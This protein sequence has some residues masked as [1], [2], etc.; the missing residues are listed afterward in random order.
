MADEE[1]GKELHGRGF[2]FVPAPGMRARLQR[3]GFAD[4]EGFA[5]S[6]NDL[7]LDIYMAD[8]GRYRRRRHAAFAVGAAAIERKPHQPHYQSRD[9]NPLNGGIERWFEPIADA[10]GR[11]P[12]MQAV[13]RFAQALFDPLTPPELRP[14]AW[15]AEV[16]QFRVEAHTGQPGLPTPEGM[17]RDGVDWVL[18]LLVARENVASGATTILDAA[19]HPVG[20]FLLAAPL[21]TALVDDSR[22]FHG[23]TPIA[24]LETTRSGHRDVL[25]VTLRR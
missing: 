9:Y 23:V 13:L 25:V 12:A 7:G 4:W 14:P 3:F 24:P 10:I 11:H 16:H 18:V 6:W 19:R 21:D 1:I 15:H 17:H 2:A 5:A 20:Q 22:V 8:G